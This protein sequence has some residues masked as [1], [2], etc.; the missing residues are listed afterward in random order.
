MVPGYSPSRRWG[1]SLTP[2]A[3]LKESKAAVHTHSPKEHH[4]S[5]DARGFP[6]PPIAG[7]PAKPGREQSHT[8][9]RCYTVPAVSYPLPFDQLPSVL[10]F[11][12]RIFG[13]LMN[14]YNIYVS[15]EWSIIKQI[16]PKPPPNLRNRT[17][18]KE[19]S[20]CSSP[21]PSWGSHPSSAATTILN[22]G[23]LA[24]FCIDVEMYHKCLYD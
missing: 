3:A 24:F 20:M 2:Q 18:P 23:S 11:F 8:L 19:V 9:N 22:L 15:Y 16:P 7:A 13:Y 4:L 17:F 1:R 21:E 12:N 10:F 5:D 6:W 14:I